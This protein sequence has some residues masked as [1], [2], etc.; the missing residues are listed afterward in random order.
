M[1]PAGFILRKRCWF[2]PLSSFFTCPQVSLGNPIFLASDWNHPRTRN[3]LGAYLLSFLPQNA[4]SQNKRH[5]G[6]NFLSSCWLL[7]SQHETTGTLASILCLWDI[8]LRA[9]QAV[10]K[11]EENFGLKLSY[12]LLSSELLAMWDKAFLLLFKLAWDEIFCYC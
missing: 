1:V 8:M 5:T 9:T 7:W 11:D 3:G 2:I 12:V 10:W 6:R 4:Y